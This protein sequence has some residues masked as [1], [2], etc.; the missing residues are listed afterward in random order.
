MP[1]L[2]HVI[3]ECIHNVQD[4][5]LFGRPKRLEVLIWTGLH[6]F[7]TFRSNSTEDVK[8]YSY[9]LSHYES[10]EPHSFQIQQML[11]MFD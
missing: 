11:E 3:I 2:F 10:T 1:S 8:I 6:T 5:N 4:N 9:I 7:F